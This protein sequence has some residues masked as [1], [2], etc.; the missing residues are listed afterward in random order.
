[1]T[2][3]PLPPPL[4]LPLRPATPPSP[5]PEPPQKPR[6]LVFPTPTHCTTFFAYSPR[7]RFK[8]TSNPLFEN[9]PAE[10]FSRSVSL[11]GSPRSLGR[12]IYGWSAHAHGS[13]GSYDDPHR[14]RGDS[15]R[16]RARDTAWRRTSRR[17]RGWSALSI[18]TIWAARRFV[19]NPKA[20]TFNGGEIIT[21]RTRLAARY[22]TA[23]PRSSSPRCVTA[24]ARDWPSAACLMPFRR[25]STYPLRRGHRPHVIR[26]S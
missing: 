16:P 5:Q 12:A 9:H 3:R 15:Q 11:C 20:G 17:I 21:P 8:D 1:M 19:E 23:M 26:I 6:P 10:A 25:N 14:T 18:A 2:A 13:T 4:P 7:P 24:S 22:P